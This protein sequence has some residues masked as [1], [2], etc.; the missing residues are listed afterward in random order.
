VYLTALQ[1]ALFKLSKFAEKQIER[2][3]KIKK[4]RNKTEENGISTN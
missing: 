3:K 1:K 2:R 4:T